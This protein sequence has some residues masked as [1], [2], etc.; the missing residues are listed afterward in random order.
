MAG[1]LEGK[2]AVITGAASGIGEGITKSFVEEGAKVVVA[3]ISGAQDAFA[4][5]LGENAAA[6]SVDVR[7]EDSVKA[8]LDS[9]VST[10][11]GIDILVNNAGIDGEVA[12]TAD[13]T[14]A[15]FD[16]IMA[17]NGR[18]VFLGMHYGIPL[19]IERGGGSIINT[20]SMA[21][22]LAF[23]G[24]IPY[25]ASKGAVQ[26]MTRTAAAEY[27]GQGI[28]VNAICPGAIRTAIT[29]SLP[30][31]LIQGVVDATLVGRFGETS[32][33]G[34]LAVYLGSD[35]SKFVTGAS[36]LIDGGYS[37]V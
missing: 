4:E 1:R 33:I 24:M 12:P 36:I 29:D 8:M 16:N 9:A 32:E 10:F 14:I 22:E 31:E 37:L 19:M 11:G 7:Q 13:Q 5:S 3:D 30:P 26:M 28:R 6:V 35:E 20:A 17:I 27:A 23:P 34:S 21:A 25:C 18:G 2:V 15:N